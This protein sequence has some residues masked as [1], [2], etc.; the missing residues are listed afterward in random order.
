MNSNCCATVQS[1]DIPGLRF[2]RKGIIFNARLGKAD[3]ALFCFAFPV[4][5]RP[6][7]RFG[8]YDDLPYQAIQIP[9]IAASTYKYMD[10]TLFYGNGFEG[11]Q[12]G[13][14]RLH[15]A[16]EEEMARNQQ[17][18]L[19]FFPIAVR[20]LSLLAVLLVTRDRSPES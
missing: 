13:D 4:V 9:G 16:E 12:K 14:Y 8:I 7:L 19:A 15:E 3:L 5:A 1:P 11:M 10:M 18:V 20:W 17:E 2:P 6:D